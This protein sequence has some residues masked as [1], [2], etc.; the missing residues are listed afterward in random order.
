[1]F[2]S[3][4]F[5]FFF[6]IQVL[7]VLL[8]KRFLNF[9]KRLPPYWFSVCFPTHYTHRELFPFK[10][11]VPS[12]LSSSVVYKFTCSSC[13]T[14]YYGKKHHAILLFAAESI[15]GLIKRVRQ[16]KAFRHPLETMLETLAIAPLAKIFVF[17]TMWVMKSIYLF[18]RAYLLLEIVPPSNSRILQYPYAF[19][20]P[21]RLLV[22]S[23]SFAVSM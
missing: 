15:E 21:L 2:P 10:D 16:S 5:L 12:H 11:R 18:T 23:L 13:K 6:P 1:M 19:F 9:R 8:L 7:V 4:P 17:Q 3:Y 14:T 22:F 20:N